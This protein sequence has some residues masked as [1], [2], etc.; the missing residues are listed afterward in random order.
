MERIAGLDEVLDECLEAEE[1]DGEALDVRETVEETVHLVFR[2]GEFHLPIFVPEIVILHGGIGLA[3]G[4]ALDVFEERAGDFLEAHVAESGH[5][6]HLELPEPLG[7]LKFYEHVVGGGDAVARFQF[8]EVL[9]DEH[10]LDEVDIA[11]SGNGQF[12]TAH[13]ISGVGV[14]QDVEMSGE[15]EVLLVVGQETHVDD[16]VLVDEDGVLQVVPVE[17]DG[18]VGDGGAERVLQQ[19]ALVLVDVHIGED[20]LQGGGEYLARVDQFGHA[21]VALAL[22]DVLL[23]LRVLS[24]EDLREGFIYGQG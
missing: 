14:E 10:V 11:A 8:R 9:G 24:V 19:A 17:G 3:Q 12:D 15:A 13:L 2:G 16:L 18:V 6:L 4:V 23:R 20:V 21:L 7:E 22:D 1:E 5:A